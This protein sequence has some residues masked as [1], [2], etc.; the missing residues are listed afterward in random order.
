MTERKKVGQHDEHS[1]GRKRY[2]VRRGQEARVGVHSTPAVT[3]ALHRE[4]RNER[5]MYERYT[6]AYHSRAWKRDML[7]VAESRRTLCCRICATT[8][9]AHR[10]GVLF[11]CTYCT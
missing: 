4:P 8:N 1:A 2:N 6:R 5:A 7:R 10:A 11:L 3:A 9:V